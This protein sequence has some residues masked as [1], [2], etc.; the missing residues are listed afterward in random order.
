MRMGRPLY[1]LL[2]GSPRKTKKNRAKIFRAYGGTT[3]NIENGD[4]M[5][6]IVNT[7]REV[8]VMREQ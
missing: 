7:M 3:S 1:V 5:A 6:G 8:N 2:D 4:D